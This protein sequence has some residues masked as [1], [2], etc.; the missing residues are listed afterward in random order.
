MGCDVDRLPT[1]AAAG[2]CDID[3]TP[4]LGAGAAAYVDE[5]SDSDSAGYYIP[6]IGP[7]RH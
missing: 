1:K 4:A 2:G 6:V 7:T 5:L 3:E